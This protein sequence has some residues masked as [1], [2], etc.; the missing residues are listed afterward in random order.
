[1]KIK[2][3]KVIIDTNVWI[4]FLIGKRM[5]F[6]KDLIV[7]KQIRIVTT[8]QLL[9]EISQVTSRE[10][11]S[12]YFPKKHVDD[13]IELLKQISEVKITKQQHAICRDIKDNFLLDLSD[14]SKADFLVTGD[15]DLLILDPF[16]K[17]RMFHPL[18]LKKLYFT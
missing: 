11:I 14:Q 5:E 18:I 8:E 10:K 12:K 1:M 3:I 7:N 17:T 15:N 2:P 4:S 16:K 13:L 9:E 6:L